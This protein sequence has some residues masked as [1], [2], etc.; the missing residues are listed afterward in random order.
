MYATYCNNRHMCA[1]DEVGAIAD[2]EQL[3]LFTINHIETTTPN[4]YYYRF[5]VFYVMR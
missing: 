4:Y 2:E 1:P 5:D 3:L